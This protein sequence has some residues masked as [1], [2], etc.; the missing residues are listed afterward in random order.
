MSGIET[1]LNQ[2]L[3]QDILLYLPL[4]GL[5][6]LAVFL[7]VLLSE[8]DRVMMPSVAGG[9]VMF[10]LTVSAIQFS[11]RIFTSE[12]EMQPPEIA[13]K[14]PKP[15][16]QPEKID[17]KTKPVAIDQRDLDKRPARETSTR[18]AD[19]EKR[20][21]DD[22]E[23]KRL[24]Q[25]RLE[26]QRLRLEAERKR[27]DAEDQQKSRFAEEKR[28][29]EQE[30][31]KMAEQ[32]KRQEEEL[33]RLEQERRA[34]ATP[35]PVSTPR[36]AGTPTGSTEVASASGGT[37]LKIVISGPLLETSKSGQSSS[38]H[39]LILVDRK[40]QRVIRPTRVKEDT[41]KKEGLLVNR[42]KLIAVNYFW[43]GV[44][45][46]FNELEPGSHSIMIDTDLGSS[47][48]HKSKMMASMDN[49][50]WNGFINLNA[51]QTTTL[52]FGGKNFMTGQLDRLR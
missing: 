50:D 48:S 51:G 14:I 46:V 5:I 41:S 49:N 36:A 3:A 10:A 25:V 30:L 45:V 40:Y 37:A 9:I 43:E 8:R 11:D 20:L 26:N 42:E 39:L 18:D 23:R 44:T 31:Q 28:K 29:L 4:L 24:E 1:A 13:V 17:D 52:V 16:A 6:L 32:K 34:A 15:Q 33:R 27:V 35:A 21:R 19:K 7:L 12:P 47:G 2:P 22:M 38:A